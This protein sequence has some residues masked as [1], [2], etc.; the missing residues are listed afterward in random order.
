MVENG[1]EKAL[2]KSTGDD[3]AEHLS[4]TLHNQDLSSGTLKVIR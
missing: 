3:D 4:N 1:T 2:Q